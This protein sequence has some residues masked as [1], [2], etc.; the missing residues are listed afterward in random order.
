M[1]GHGDYLEVKLY[2][3]KQLGYIRC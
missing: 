1:L 2:Y 3:L